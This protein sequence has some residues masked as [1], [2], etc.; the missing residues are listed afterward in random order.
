MRI[1]ARDEVC[2]F[3]YTRA[4]WGALSNF[5][6]LTAPVAAGPWRFLTSEALY[7]AAKFPA[8]PNVQ[9]RIAEARR[10]GTLPPSGARRASSSARPGARNVSTSCDGCCG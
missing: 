10:R 4:E 5:G 6:R 7:Q 1:Y 3:R 9:Q 8:H 2:A